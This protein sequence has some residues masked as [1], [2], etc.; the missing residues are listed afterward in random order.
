MKGRTIVFGATIGVALFA[1]SAAYAWSPDPDG[2][3]NLTCGDGSRAQVA[4]QADGSWTVTQ[5]GKK[6]SAGGSFTTMGKAAQA[7]C[8]EN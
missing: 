3:G 6:G 5:P 1:G 8:G 2:S 7:A 4:Q